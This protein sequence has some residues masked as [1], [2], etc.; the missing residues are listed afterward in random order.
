MAA[1]SAPR[2]AV[3]RDL[4]PP[5]RIP[6]AAEHADAV[7]IHADVAGPVEGDDSTFTAAAAQL[8]LNH[9][10][11]RL[12]ERHAPVVHECT[13]IVGHHLADEVL[14]L[15]GAGYRTGLVARI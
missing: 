6:R 1:P 9:L 8:D 4:P 2:V 13:Y 10:V 12:R 3:H 7:E 11:H 5:A 14:A 15:P